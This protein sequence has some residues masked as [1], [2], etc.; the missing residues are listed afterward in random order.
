MVIGCRTYMSMDGRGGLKGDVSTRGGQI[1]EQP[2]EKGSY[3]KN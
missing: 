2:K 1:L 3:R